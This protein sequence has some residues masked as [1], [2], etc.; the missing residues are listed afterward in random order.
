MWTVPVPAMRAREYQMVFG[1]S[2]YEISPGE[3]LVDVGSGNTNLCPLSRI[4]SPLTIFQLD[5]AYKRLPDEKLLGHAE[6]ATFTRVPIALG[7]DTELTQQTVAKIAKTLL[8][9]KQAVRVT[10]ANTMRYLNKKQQ[11]IAIVQMLKMAN[12]GLVQIYPFV[13]NSFDSIERNSAEAGVTATMHRV[14]IVGMRQLGHSLVGLNNTLTV[15]MRGRGSQLYY[16]ER[17]PLAQHI[18]ACLSSSPR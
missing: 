7:L 11:V 5:P 8:R 3:H 12:G 10:S 16:Q 6:T 1:F 13:D 17:L 2:P 4:A 14:A 18:A 15:D 9:S